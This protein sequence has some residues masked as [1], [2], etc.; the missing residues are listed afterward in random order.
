MHYLGKCGYNIDND[1]S[2]FD[3]A[4]RLQLT[5]LFAYDIGCMPLHKLLV[6]YGPVFG[7]K[8]RGF[9]YRVNG[10]RS[11]GVCVVI[12]CDHVWDCDGWD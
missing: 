12:L 9:D 5:E 6:G 10:H 8:L 7:G 2:S 11:I 4:F 1:L 3:T